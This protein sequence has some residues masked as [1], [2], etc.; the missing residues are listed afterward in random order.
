MDVQEM[1]ANIEARRKEDVKNIDVSEADYIASPKEQESITTDL[2]IYQTRLN[3]RRETNK[4]QFP[5]GSSQRVLAILRDAL[6]GA[7]GRPGLAR[8]YKRAKDDS[9]SLK[10][11]GW[12]ERANNI[13]AQYMEEQFLP[14]VEV[15]V[16]FT[17]PDELLNNKKALDTL[18]QYVLLEGPG[19]GYTAS[20]VRSAYG[21]QLGA[22]PGLS[23]AL[24]AESVRRIKRMGS[25]DNI[26]GAYALA[27]K[28]K[29]KVDK[30]EAMA[31]D[32]DYAM[33]SGVAS[34]R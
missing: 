33:L 34:I 15:V 17:S 2:D 9:D 18:D 19:R 27:R 12:R 1:L 22:R 4:K 24:V 23:D 14:V 30:G 28:I 20:Y 11:Q 25:M 26:R 32:E 5:A 31:S 10:E 29:D 16:N 7:D 3:A 6:T 13:R 8:S 21:D